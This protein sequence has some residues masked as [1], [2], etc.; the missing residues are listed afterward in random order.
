MFMT[1]IVV[2]Q[3]QISRAAQTL[4]G[5]Q[6]VGYLTKELVS[7]LEIKPD[8]TIAKQ[9]DEKRRKHQLPPQVE[10]PIYGS[11]IRAQSETY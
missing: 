3:Q 10:F 9:S 8:L 5:H 1:A 11:S 6:D 7:W 2:I 4:A